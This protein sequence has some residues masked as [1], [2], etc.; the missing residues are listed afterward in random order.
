[1]SKLDELKARSRPLTWGEFHEQV[2]DGLDENMKVVTN[3]VEM[4][5][6]REEL[7]D[8][9]LHDAL[10]LYHHIVAQSYKRKE[11]EKN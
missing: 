4:Q 8:L 2:G 9:P 5:F 7:L 11:E 10:D 3:V 6:D 1:M